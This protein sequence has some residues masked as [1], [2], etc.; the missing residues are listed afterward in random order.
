MYII[1]YIS[2]SKADK[3]MEFGSLWSQSKGLSFGN[4]PKFLKC[5]QDTQIRKNVRKNVF[6]SY[7]SACTADKWTNLNSP[8]P[9]SKGLS[10]GDTKD[11]QD[12]KRAH[13]MCTKYLKRDS[14]RFV[15]DIGSLVANFIFKNEKG[16]FLKNRRG[17]F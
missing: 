17:E 8:W 16:L 2:A 13:K 14:S 1:V 5:T 7:N 12:T 3:W 10:F 15:P 11:T 4:T 9:Q 6:L